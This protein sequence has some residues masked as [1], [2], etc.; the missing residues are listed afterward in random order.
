M[1]KLQQARKIINEVDSEMARLFQRRMQ[2]AE[3]VAEYKREHGL[4][5]L[6][7]A[8]EEQVI[9]R[10]LEFIHEDELRSFYTDFLKNTMAVSRDYQS[11][12]LGGMKVAY[13]GTEGAF[14]HIASRK[15][16]PTA[17]HV[18]FS[19]FEEAYRSVLNGKC[20]VAVLPIENSYA[21]EVGQVTDL[22]F[23]G[24]LFINGIY[25]FSIT[26][27][28][29]AL[30]GTRLSDLQ[31]VVSHP[32][33][34]SQ[35]ADF[36][37]ENNL[38]EIQFSNTALA[39]EYVAKEGNPQLAAIAS[40]DAAQRFGLEILKKGINASQ[41]NTTRFA[42]F[43]RAL[44]HNTTGRMGDRFILLFTV[45]NEAGSLV[46]ALDIIGHHGFNMS[47]LRSRP[48]K[49]LLWNYFFFVEAEGNVFGWNGKEMLDELQDCCDRL[50]LVGAYNKSVDIR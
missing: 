12:L 48:Q 8:R 37:H 27:D 40:E 25:D 22:M 20:D 9:S 10:N 44:S 11:Y 7:S 13:C 26:Q 24:P 23:S 49:D 31:T 19:A 3:M 18:A 5:I 30:P 32:Q 14:A 15:L 42:V 28:L 36:I 34:L 38:R 16:F 21:G 41:N 4:P 6:D 33:A 39:A 45:K 29:L 50:K 43:S 17:S 2:A 1:D 46:K 35:C 47:V